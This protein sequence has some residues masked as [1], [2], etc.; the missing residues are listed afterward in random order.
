MN[1]VTLMAHLAHQYP[2]GTL[3]LS[4]TLDKHDDG[5]TLCVVTVSSEEAIKVLEIPPDTWVETYW[6]YSNEGEWTYT[7]TGIYRAS[8][9]EESCEV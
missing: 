6:E 1:L 5:I 2:A 8:P 7:E 3:I 9:M 4:I